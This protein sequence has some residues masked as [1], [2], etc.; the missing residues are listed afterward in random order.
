MKRKQ[1]F[2]ILALAYYE[3]AGALLCTV[4]PGGPKIKE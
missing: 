2:L 1:Y 3:M 4:A